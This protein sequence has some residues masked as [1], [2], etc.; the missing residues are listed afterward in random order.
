M[1]ICRNLNPYAS[2]GGHCS[3]PSGICLHTPDGRHVVSS[4][5][6]T[7][8]TSHFFRHFNFTESWQLA[9]LAEYLLLPWQRASD[10]CHVPRWGCVP[11]QLWSQEVPNRSIHPVWKRTGEY[12]EHSTFLRSDSSNCMIKGSLRAKYFFLPF[13]KLSPFQGHVRPRLTTWF[14][15][16]IGLLLHRSN[17]RSYGQFPFLSGE[18]LK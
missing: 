16:G 13:F 4:S 2:S 10:P 15:S 12:V 7:N 14:I 9:F 11:F 3:T 5:L 6:K 18:L 8:P 17:I 1:S